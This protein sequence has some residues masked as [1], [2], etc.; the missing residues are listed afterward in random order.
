MDRRG[1]D[2]R[3]RLKARKDFV[4]VYGKGRAWANR[5]LVLRALPNGLPNTRCGFVVSKRVG[6]AVVRNR[7]KRRLREGLRPL[8]TVTGRDLVFLA[9]PPAA[10]ASYHDLREAIA[11]LLSRARLLDRGDPVWQQAGSTGQ[12]GEH[13]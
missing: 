13:K 5:L 8:A 3:E 6:K 9:R 2:K 7:L 12:T 10:Q 4:A 11:D 1:M